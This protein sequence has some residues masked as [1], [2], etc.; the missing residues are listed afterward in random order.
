MS[1]VRFLFQLPQAN[2]I[3]GACVTRVHVRRKQKKTKIFFFFFS[4]F[5][6]FS[7]T[8]KKTTTTDTQRTAGR[9]HCSA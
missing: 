3:T 6:L 4:R 2:N 1:A 5:C 8:E 7:K 9:L